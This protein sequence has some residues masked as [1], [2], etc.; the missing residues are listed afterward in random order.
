MGARHRAVDQYRRRLSPVEN[1][2]TVTSTR[3][4]PTRIS[5]VLL[6]KAWPHVLWLGA[7][8][9]PNVEDILT[10]LG[11]APVKKSG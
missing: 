5:I 6:E 4:L 8:K 7:K 9:T 11:L 2:R 3:H 1:C 10:R